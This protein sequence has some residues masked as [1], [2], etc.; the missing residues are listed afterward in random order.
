MMRVLSIVLRE[1][2][3]TGEHKLVIVLCGIMEIDE[4]TLVI[5][6]YDPWNEQVRRAT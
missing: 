5:V 6:L 1:I 2:I 3:E 4:A